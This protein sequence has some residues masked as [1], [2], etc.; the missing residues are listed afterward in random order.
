MPFKIWVIQA[1]YCLYYCCAY[2]KAN[3]ETNN[4]LVLCK[5]NDTNDIIRICSFLRSN[6]LC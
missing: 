3:Y 6:I 2:N 1:Q 4:S 5:K